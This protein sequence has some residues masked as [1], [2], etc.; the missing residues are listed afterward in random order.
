MTI[1]ICSLKLFIDTLI[2]ILSVT[3]HPALSLILSII[4]LVSF[5]LPSNTESPGMEFQRYSNG[6]IPLTVDGVNV[7][8]VFGHTVKSSPRETENP[9]YTVI[10]VLKVSLAPPVLVM[11]RLTFF[12]PVVFHFITALLSV[13]SVI[14]PSSASHK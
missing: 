7:N 13:E 10:V 12:S 8:S 9:A 11:A 5:R 1:Q 6:L 14:T 2:L 4:L 3:V